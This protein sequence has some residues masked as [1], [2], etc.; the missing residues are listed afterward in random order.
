MK[1]LEQSIE[2][3]IPI[4][5]AYDPSVRFDELPK[6]I[7]GVQEVRHEGDRLFW[8]TE[9]KGQKEEWEIRIIEQIPH[10]KIAWRTV[11]GIPINGIITFHY[12]TSHLTQVVFRMKSM[13]CDT[14]ENSDHILDR[15]SK[16]ISKD[17]ESFKAFVE[18]GE[19]NQSSLRERLS[20][21]NLE[22]RF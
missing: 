17:M 18:G 14:Q 20:N 3:Q 2:V 19:H 21:F 11:E 16:R 5:E 9:S 15:V 4:A 7:D 22:P 1:E 10:K 6:F 8:Q 13:S 12:I